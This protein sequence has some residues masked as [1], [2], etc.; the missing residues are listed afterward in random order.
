MLDCLGLGWLHW[1]DLKQVEWA[2][3]LQLLAAIAGI[4]LALYI[5]VRMKRIE[6]YERMRGA[7]ARIKGLDVLSSLF[8]DAM[9][10]ALDIDHPPLD[11]F[12]T[13]LKGCTALIEDPQTDADFIPIIGRAVAAV[14]AM[15][16]HWQTRAISRSP[17]HRPN[18]V[19]WVSAQRSAL[20]TEVLAAETLVKNW[21]KT[22]WFALA[23]E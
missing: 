2:A 16:T 12:T 14:E 4:A 1:P 19:T 7:A 11:N 8:Q 22:H 13:R 9:N 10:P 21:R 23:F 3:W 20:A 6:S 5:P 17:D 18:D 15:R